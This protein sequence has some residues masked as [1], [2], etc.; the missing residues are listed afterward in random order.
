MYFTKLSLGGDASS[1]G[2]PSSGVRGQP[3]QRGPRAWGRTG[4]TLRPPFCQDPGTPRRAQALC[5][6]SQTQASHEKGDLHFA[7]EFKKTALFK[8]KSVIGA[9]IVGR[10]LKGSRGLLFNLIKLLR[11]KFNLENFSQFRFVVELILLQNNFMRWAPGFK[12]YRIW[13]R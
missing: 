8:K 12:D 2:E 10:R 4:R 13:F 5:R 11:V 6:N 3:P 7:H 9:L 1:V